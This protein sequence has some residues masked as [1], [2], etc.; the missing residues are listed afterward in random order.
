M[1]DTQ[2]PWILVGYE[3]FAKE[4]PKGLK[5]ELL[6]RRVQ[7]S[8]SSF[9]HHFADLDVFTEVLLH[10]HLQQAK[11]IAE[12]ERLC[13]N[14]DPDLIDVLIDAK[15]DLLFNRQLRVNRSNPTFAQFIEKAD[16]EVEH[17]FLQVWARDIGLEGKPQLANSLLDLS[18]ENFYLQLT[19]ET[20]NREWLTAYFAEIR[21]M[22]SQFQKPQTG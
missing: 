11:L 14:I 3:L 7:K 18:L 20:L 17:A 9:Y 22:V 8:K 12:R 4:G 21:S 6:A 19:E 10:A 2:R 15:L 16:K 13:K 1:S 5:V